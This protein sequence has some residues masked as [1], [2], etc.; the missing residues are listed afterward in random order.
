MKATW[1]VLELSW[2]ALGP[3][4]ELLGAILGASWAVLG[5]RKPENAVTPKSFQNL[6]KINE[7]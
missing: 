4:W 6:K 5:C 7:N 3:A 1:A 2:A